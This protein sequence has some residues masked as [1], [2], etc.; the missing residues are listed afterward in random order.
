MADDEK[1][2]GGESVVKS[3]I[4]VTRPMSWQE[5]AEARGEGPDLADLN[6]NAPKPVASNE[7]RPILKQMKRRHQSNERKQPAT[8]SDV[9]I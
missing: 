6:P 4:V 5:R 7:Y 9:K 8:M 3:R 1:E 2:S